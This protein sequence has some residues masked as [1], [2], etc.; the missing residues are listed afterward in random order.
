MD[1]DWP[2]RFILEIPETCSPLSREPVLVLSLT[3]K[4]DKAN[5]VLGKYT[6]LLPETIQILV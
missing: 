4:K 5:K 1:S 6:N 2:Q 3:I